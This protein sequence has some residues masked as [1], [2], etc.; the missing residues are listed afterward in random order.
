M[1]LFTENIII[2]N[3]VGINLFHKEKVPSIKKLF[4]YLFLTKE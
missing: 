2:S 3:H 1:I 4:Y